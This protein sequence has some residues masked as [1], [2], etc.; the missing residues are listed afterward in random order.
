VLITY[1]A[2]HVKF[3]QK[4]I[5]ITSK[6]VSKEKIGL[7]VLGAGNFARHTMLPAVKGLRDLELVGIASASGRPAADLANRFGFRYATSDEYQIL[8]DRKID[9][10]S[11]V[12]RHNLH[13]S[14]TL[15]ALNAGK[16]VFCEKPLALSEKE[17]SSIEKT[18]RRRAAPRLMV[19]FN[20]R[21]APLATELQ[22][23][24]APRSA[25]LAAHY[26]VNA[27]PLPLYHWLH[28]P[29]RGGGRLLGEACHFIDFLIF[30]A[31]QVPT[32][33]FA[34][35]LPEGGQYRQ[36]NFQVTMRF[37]DGSLG[38]LTYLANGD[39]SLPKERLEVFSGGKVA[40]L[41]DFRALDLTANGRTRRLRRAQDKGHQRAWKAFIASL[42]H[43]GQ[44]PIPY[45][46]IFA[47]ARAAF[48]AQQS[49]ETGREIEL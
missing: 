46:Q 33:V 30:L 18:L 36:D 26:R 16:H 31:G 10:V 39:R 9:A 7:G 43:S 21:F 11:I 4:K 24:L 22:K 35:A 29:T 42:K 45:D 5:E 49:L 27:G 48:A 25:P 37:A 28:D 13:A 14:Q 15:A 38:T 34:Q 1:P 23:F 6:P 17:L 20:R 12:T 44:P 19:G 32:S 2:V 47:G 40:I 3:V 8:S 41:E